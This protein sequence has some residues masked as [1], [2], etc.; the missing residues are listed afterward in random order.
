MEMKVCIHLREELDPEYIARFVQ[1]ANRFES[2][3][4]L[5]VGEEHRVDAKSI[6]G[7]MNF[8]AQ[9]GQEVVIRAEGADAREAVEALAACFEGRK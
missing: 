6:M 4:Y 9:D 5:Q 8:L 1:A 2:S 3:L 7:M